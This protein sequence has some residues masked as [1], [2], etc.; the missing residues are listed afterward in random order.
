VFIIAREFSFCAAHRLTR[1]PADHKCHRLHGHNYTGWTEVAGESLD[2]RGF[3]LDFGELD[4]VQAF[5]KEKWDHRLLNDVVS[6][7]PTAENLAQYLCSMA[8]AKWP[9]LVRAVRIFE[10]DRSWAEFRV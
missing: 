1:V 8:D 6:F 2:A 3:V 10:N 7:E 4:L 5:V 9:G